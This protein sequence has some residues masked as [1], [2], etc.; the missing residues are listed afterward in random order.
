MKAAV[1]LSS[2]GS[3][4]G[5]IPDGS[6]TAGSVGGSVG[7]NVGMLGMVSAGVEGAVVLNVGSVAG[8]CVVAGCVVAHPATVATISA[9]ANSAC[10]SL[11]LYFLIAAPRS[12]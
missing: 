12:S 11:C 1:P 9:K 2:G 4:S 3:S 8:R 10:I 5:S 6:V 7:G